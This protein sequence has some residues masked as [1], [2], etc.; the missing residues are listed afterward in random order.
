MAIRLI[1]AVVPTLAVLLAVLLVAMEIRHVSRE[2]E[3]SRHDSS[4]TAP[5]RLAIDSGGLDR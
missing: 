3:Q 4:Y 2:W 1:N 5:P